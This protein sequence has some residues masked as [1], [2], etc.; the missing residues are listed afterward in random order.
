MKKLIER[1]K[2]G[3]FTENPVFVQVLAMCPTLAVTSSVENAIGMGLAATAV[4]IGS[5]AVIS[6]LRKL[7]PDK[8]RIP[9]FIVVIAS[10]VTL[11][12]FLV[13]AYLPELYKSLGIFIPLIVVNCI[14]LGR[15][16][17][18]ASKNSVVSSIFDAIGMGLGFTVALTVLACIRELLG[19]GTIYGFQVLPSSYE[20]MGIM[21]L[22]PGAFITLGILLA[23]MN[24]AKISKTNKVKISKEKSAE[25]IK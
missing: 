5:N 17:A 4:L 7:I 11:I 9:A 6:L 8:I 24:Q 14:I 12:Q 23:I 22:A 15:A 20:P 16:E 21:Q 25:A 10:F 13:Q 3:L 1:L 19:A 2:T 18:Y